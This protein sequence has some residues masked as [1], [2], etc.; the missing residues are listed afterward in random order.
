MEENNTSDFTLSILLCI[1]GL[2]VIIDSIELIQIISSWKVD[3]LIVPQVFEK[4]IKFQLIS[5]TIFSVFSFVSALSSFFLTL[6][7]LT[8]QNFFLKKL[9]KAYLYLNYYFFGPLMMGLS[10]LGIYNWEHV[11]YICNKNDLNKKDLIISN[12]VTVISCFL[13]SVFLTVLV[14]FF[15]AFYFLLDS[16][17]K[18]N[19]GSHILGKFFWLF[20][21]SRT[22]RARMRA[23]SGNNNNIQINHQ[24]RN[25]IDNQ[26][27]IW[28]N[29]DNGNIDIYNQDTV[30][31]INNNFLNNINLIDNNRNNMIFINDRNTNNS[32]LKNEENEGFLKESFNNKNNICPNEIYDHNVLSIDNNNVKEE[33]LNINNKNELSENNNLKK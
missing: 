27:N 9:L 25:N 32:I 30:I 4:C 3:F 2:L 15:E 20:A 14:E 5:K 6:L 21:L 17:L 7:L 28:N 29:A 18:R 10:L 12:S 24:N 26:N 16:I 23:F 11:V 1:S 31:D 13:V 22:N 19:S 33:T 8:A